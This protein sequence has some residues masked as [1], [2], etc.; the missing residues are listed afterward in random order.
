MALRNRVWAVARAEVGVQEITGRNDHPHILQYHKSVS[1]Y[2]FKLRP[3]PP[4]CA[5][6]VNFAYKLGGAKIRDVPNPARA[7]NWFLAKKRLVITQQSLRG[8]SRMMK[9]P[10]RGDIVGYYFQRHSNA[11]SHIEILDWIDFENGWIYVIGA[12]TS[13]SNSAIT[14]DRNGD[15][16]YYL[17]RKIKSFHRIDNIIDP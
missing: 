8:N 14:V 10:K 12:N 5:S 6:F 13:S 7:R 17:R 11:I 16:V 1:D 9:M 3:V 4:Y 2:L 15:G